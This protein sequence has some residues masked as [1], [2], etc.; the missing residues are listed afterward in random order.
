MKGGIVANDS[1]FP[2]PVCQERLVAEKI[3]RPAS[4]EAE[5]DGDGSVRGNHRPWWAGKDYGRK[6]RLECDKGHKF[7]TVERIRP[8]E[9][10]EATVTFTG[11]PNPG[12]YSRGRL[13][14]ELSLKLG[15]VLDKQLR[16][17]VVFRVEHLL[18]I[19]GENRRT[20]K[21]R[22]ATDIADAV[23]TVL[24]NYSKERDLAQAVADSLR[25]A[26][27]LYALSQEELNFTHSGRTQSLKG[28]GFEG[29]KGVLDWLSDQYRSLG[30]WDE[31]KSHN[32]G[33]RRDE[34]HTLRADAAPMPKTLLKRLARER[35]IVVFGP[36]GGGAPTVTSTDEVTV[37][38]V[39]EEF[40]LRI[41][42]RALRRVF[43]GRP[44]EELNVTYTAQ[45]VLFA[46]AGQN[47]IRA[48]DLVAMTT[49]CLRRVDAIAY[50]RWA[51]IAKNLTPV[52][53]TEEI[54]GMLEWPAPRLS[55]APDAAAEMRQSLQLQPIRPDE[56]SAAELTSVMRTEARH[57]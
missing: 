15:T 17:E 48:S 4:A 19:Q 20:L 49:Q 22:P 18:M 39:R 8:L 11:R 40:E 38:W 36:D 43:A 35:Q 57:W 55:F 13:H 28:D 53:L 9:Y 6:R 26:H 29:L 42:D 51:I 46:L 21:T 44:N 52:A 27:V 54:V 3:K 34:W 56:D 50:L 7:S 12:P 23:I 25:K 10:L 30:P 14:S 32:I 37:E 47:T 5:S 33:K 24:R 41:Y 2:C 16:N 31:V 1:K 45:W